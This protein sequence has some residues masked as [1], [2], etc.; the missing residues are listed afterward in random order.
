MVRIQNCRSNLVSTR[1]Q[2]VTDGIDT[3]ILVK[4]ARVAVIVPKQS[5]FWTSCPTDGDLFPWSKRKLVDTR[6]KFQIFVLP[7]WFFHICAQSHRYVNI[8][9]QLPYFGDSCRIREFLIARFYVMNVPTAID[10]EKHGPKTS[11]AIQQALL[12]LEQSAFVE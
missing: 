7:D 1:Q 10:R 4:D 12:P 5:Q 9:C 6:P 2:N 8:Q 11:R 3:L